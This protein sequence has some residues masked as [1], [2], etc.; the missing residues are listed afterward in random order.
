MRYGDVA[1]G[2]ASDVASYGRPV[3]AGLFPLAGGYFSLRVASGI[4][5]WFGRS[6]AALSTHGRPIAVV[7]WCVALQL[8]SCRPAPE[9]RH[10]CSDG[11]CWLE[12]EI[13]EYI[14]R[15]V[16]ALIFLVGTFSW[17]FSITFEKIHG[18][19]LAAEKFKF[20][21]MLC[22]GDP[23]HNPKCLRVFGAS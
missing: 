4:P 23:S 18:V 1:S 14:P 12:L 17:Y 6:H 8:R 11:G 2:V 3:H 7:T 19:Q 9:T 20:E 21:T 22:S 16:S 10:L 15:V 13:R 5:E